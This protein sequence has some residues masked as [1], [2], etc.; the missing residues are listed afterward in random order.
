MKTKDFL[1]TVCL[2]I[3]YKPVRDGIA[4]ELK[5]HIQ[6]IKEDYI[7]KGIEEQ[8]AEEKA[9]IQMGNAEEIGKK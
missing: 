8:K 1:N 5:T 4:E 2:E 9:V 7:N 6:D 3:K